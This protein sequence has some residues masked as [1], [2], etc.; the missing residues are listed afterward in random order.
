MFRKKLKHY[1]YALPYMKLIEIIIVKKKAKSI[2]LKFDN[3]FDFFDTY[4]DY[5]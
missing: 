4:A 5:S 2:V 1:T 3:Y